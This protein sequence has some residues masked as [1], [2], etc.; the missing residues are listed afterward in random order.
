LAIAADKLVL[1]PGRTTL[2]PASEGSYLAKGLSATLAIKLTTLGLSFVTLIV[3]SRLL[4]PE[5]YGEYA[6]VM[7]TVAILTPLAA[8]GMHSIIV[9]EVAAGRARGDSGRMKGAVAFALVVGMVA[10]IIVALAC[11]LFEVAAAT[12]WPAASA[13]DHLLLALTLLLLA[14]LAG[15]CSAI[16]QGLKRIVAAQIPFAIVQPLATVLLLLL[17]WWAWHTS[18]DARDAILIAALAG[19]VALSIAVALTRHAWREAKPSKSSGFQF[20]TRRWATAGFSLSLLGLLSA[21]NM[22]ADIVLLRWLAG[23]EATGIFHVATRNANLLTLL[24]G[25]LVVPLGPLVAEFHAKGDHA[26][27]QRAVRQS[28]RLVFVLTLPAALGMIVAGDLYL[29]LFGAGFA[30]ARAALAILA[31]AQL[32][33]VGAGPVQMLLV[34]TGHPSRIIPAMS[35]SLLANVVL[36]AVLIPRFGATGAACATAFSIVLWNLALAYEVRRSLG[37]DAGVLALPLRLRSPGP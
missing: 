35:W 15:L 24:L 18:I 17:A 21:A 6:Y 12:W 4:G 27:L 37:I 33:N 20:D 19:A 25:A 22:Q 29:S 2:G 11:W 34:M 36:N 9:R 3:L 8:A 13:G 7:A 31:L 30:D 10:L 16:Q 23:T 5:G 14:N 1:D 28:I 26:A 32:V